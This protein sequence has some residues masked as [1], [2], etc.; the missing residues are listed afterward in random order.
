MKKTI[1]EEII[2]LKVYF[3]KC[4]ITAGSAASITQCAL[5]I[6]MLPSTVLAAYHHSQ[7][8]VEI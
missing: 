3:M 8:I 6:W 2:I 5:A 7:L 4:A 1:I